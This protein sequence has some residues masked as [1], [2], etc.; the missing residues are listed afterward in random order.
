[1]SKIDILVFSGPLHSSASCSPDSNS[2]NIDRPYVN[3]AKFYDD[4]GSTDSAE[5]DLDGACQIL[6]KATKINFKVVE[7][8][9]DICGLLFKFADSRQSLPIQARLFKSLKLWSFYVDLEESIGTV[10]LTKAVYDKIMDLK[11]ANAQVIVNYA[12]FLEGN[13][14]WEY[15]FKVWFI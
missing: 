2:R 3:F 7:D 5:P 10:E 13:Q 6:E 4:G 9:A 1:M 8:L 14:Y 15:H 11:I 12:A